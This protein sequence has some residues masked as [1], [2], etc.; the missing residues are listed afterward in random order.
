MPKTALQSQALTPMVTAVANSL[1][2]TLTDE[3]FSAGWGTNTS[4]LD[5]GY[6]GGIGNNL[7]LANNGGIR[8]MYTYASMLRQP[9]IAAAAKVRIML[10]LSYLQDYKHEDTVIQEDIRTQLE[11]MPGSFKTSQSQMASAIYCGASVTE[12]WYQIVG[13]K[14]EIAGLR[15]VDPRYIKYKIDSNGD[16]EIRFRKG[17]L[18]LVLN[19]VIHIK[20]D[21][22]FN[23]GNSPAGVATLDR[24]VPF[25]EQYRLV[26]LSMAI[27]AQRQATP[28]LVGKNARGT[29]ESANVFLGNL[30]KAR[31]S[32]VVVID[33]EDT[34]ES[35]AQ[36]TDGAFFVVVL[37]VLRQSILMSFLVPETILGQGESGSGDSNLNAGHTRILRMNSRTEAGIFGEKLIEQLIRPVVEFNYGNIGNWGEFPLRVDEPDDPNGLITALN[38][39][40]QAAIL[41]AE[42][43]AQR[44]E[45]LAGM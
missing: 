43:T 28:L 6:G 4:S 42:E 33:A 44:I 22:E 40:V 34:I 2:L 21:E 19:D 45:E 12:K 26:M 10:M 32:G 1:G 38:K 20:N 7:S 17:D 41:D 18:D 8:S 27:A 11:K 5:Y 3:W 14:A 24:A 15:W 30:E 23:F 36:Q 13:K 29:I 39:S 16:L 31:N 25:W 35:I 9:W 37:R